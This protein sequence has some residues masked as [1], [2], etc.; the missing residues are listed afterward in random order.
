MNDNSELDLMRQKIEKLINQGFI[1]EASDVLNK[2]EHLFEENKWFLATKSVIYML[3]GEIES[4]ERILKSAII[5]Y[6]FNADTLFNLAYLYE[7]K[8]DY[9]LAY[10]YYLD[11][12]FVLSPAE[13]ENA[14]QAAKKLKSICYDLISKQKIAIFVKPGL[15]NFIDDIVAELATDYRVRK[16]LVNSYDQIDQGMEW[17]D[18][19]WFEW[20][21]E[22]V[23]YGS[24]KEKSLNQKIICRLHSYEAFSPYIK[25]VNWPNVDKV[26][27]VAE[28]I[29]QYVLG[30]EPSLQENQSIV[31]P[32]G[33]NI[34]KFTYKE[35]EKGYNIAYVGYINYKKGPMLLLQAFK[36]IYDHDSRYKLY[37]AGEFQDP[38]YV[39]YFKQMI[40]EMGLQH[41]IYFD[42]WQ[43]DINQWLEDKHYIISTS[44][45]ESQHLSIMEAMAKGIK[46]LVHN[47]VGA[48][49]VYHE[50]Y[51]W[52]TTVDLIKILEQS[53]DPRSYHEFININYNSN[54][55]LHTL[56]HLMKQITQKKIPR[57]LPLVTVGV[58]NYN[59]K[60]FLDDCLNSI[61][62]QTYHNLDILI[63]DDCSTDGSIGTI[64]ELQK[65]HSNVR[66][67]FHEKNV[68]H[69]IKA[70]QEIIE[71][72]VGDFI[73][74]VSADDFFAKRTAIEEYVNELLKNPE[75]DYVYGN[76]Q[77]VDE[78]KKPIELWEYNDYLSDEI[79]KLVFERGGSGVI[80]MTAGIYRSR[81]YKSNKANWIHNEEDLVGAD[82]YNSLVN[83]KRGWKTKYINKT[84]YSYR[85]HEKNMST[86]GLKKRINSLVIS[87]EYIVNNFS[88]RIY[89][90]EVDWDSIDSS[91]CNL[92]KDYQIG[93]NYYKW[94]EYYHSNGFKLAGQEMS[95]DKK[96][97]LDSLNPLLE[98]SEK[99]I[100]QSL[101]PQNPYYEN[102][103]RLLENIEVYLH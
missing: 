47:F 66:T 83:A 23:I 50:S 80:P 10:D 44:V 18:I 9:Q 69:A 36:A 93:L 63:I 88:E 3:N 11:A 38:R 60:H 29:K 95:Y 94:F 58:I 1:K 65:K 20:C 84:L 17:A 70:I 67:I 56:L 92:I 28:H 71:Y 96:N 51:V 45:L 35:R 22:L 100:K 82:T 31:I 46:P 57:V 49:K 76:L 14:R 53:Y 16:I 37:I 43:N 30:Q 97:I 33:I 55:Q 12:E 98:L 85:R 42:G 39:L 73:L 19:C 2:Y 34:N 79:V 59:Y 75:I 74:M 41:N 68:G 13:K 25:Q 102:S 78:E 21:D 101:D 5:K 54:S 4:A 99:Y 7:Q 81:F 48:K 91:I 72:S 26:I 8:Q 86:N 61:L 27:F 103:K 24:K 32:N 90:S 6:P 87:L 15:D 52:N 77:V 89:L 40:E 64:N 62:N